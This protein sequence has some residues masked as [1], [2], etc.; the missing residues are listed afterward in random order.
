MDNNYDNVKL[1]QLIRTAKGSLSNKAFA[2]KLGINESYLS[3]LI[4][5]KQ[6]NKPSLDLLADIAANASN[7]VSHDDL[8]KVAGYQLSSNHQEFTL[9]NIDYKFMQGAILTSLQSTNF[10][11]PWLVMPTVSTFNLSISIED[12]S[13]NN[14][15]FLFLGFVNPAIRSN[16]FNTHYLN[17]LFDKDLSHDKI[18]FVTGLEEEYDY[19]LNHN[20]QNLNLNLSIILVDEKSLSIV[21]EDWLTSSSESIDLSKYSYKL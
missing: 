4:N 1:G 7:N 10:S 8:L 19:Y 18:S 13:I 6:K 2:V 17:L 15:H 3:R 5:A 9:P 11:F 12:G 21:K 16:Q 14:W 20:P